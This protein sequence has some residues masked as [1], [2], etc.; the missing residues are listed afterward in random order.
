MRFKFRMY[1]E[2]KDVPARTSKSKS[3]D[4]L[5]AAKRKAREPI[6]VEVLGC[7]SKKFSCDRR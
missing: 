3:F 4:N 6:T 7:V 5:G 2:E 1:K